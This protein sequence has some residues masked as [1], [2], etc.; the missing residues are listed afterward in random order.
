MKV[1]LRKVRVAL[2]LIACILYVLGF[3]AWTGFIVF[4]VIAELAGWAFLL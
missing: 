3:P 2:L 4:G 1:H